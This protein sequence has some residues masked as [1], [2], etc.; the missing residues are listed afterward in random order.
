MR[1]VRRFPRM[2]GTVFVMAA[3]LGVTA[4][5]ATTTMAADFTGKRITILVPFSEGGGT[6]SWT[7]MMSPY[8]EKHLPGKPRVIVLNRPGAAGITGANYFQEKAPK[9]GTW[10]FALSVSTALNYALKDPK[11][12]TKF[13]EYWPVLNSPRGSVVFTRKELGLQDAKGLKGKIDKLRSIPAEQMPMGGR[14]PTSIDLAYLVSLSLLGVEVKSVWGLGGTGPMALGIERGEFMIMGENALAFQRLRK[15]MI[16]GGIIYPFYTWGSYDAEGKYGRDPSMPH[17]PNF[18]EVYKA[19]NGK[20]PS[21]PGF[22]AWKALIGLDVPMNKSLLLH[23]ATSKDVVDT[24]VTAV[25]AMLADKEFLEKA[26]AELGPYPQI[27]GEA[28]RPIMKQSFDIPAPA[29]QWLSNYVKTRY[30]VT[31]GQ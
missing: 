17:L 28:V 29:R 5:T 27:V 10:I 3:A 19:A 14:T 9:D 30:D 6:D 20:E 7:R 25:K 13:E 16:D 4:G 24:W 2:A 23:P 1:S 26:A 18:V 12:K 15:H 21:G 11:F 31:I 22:D 8:L